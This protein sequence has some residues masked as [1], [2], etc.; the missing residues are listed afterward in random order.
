MRYINPRLTLTLTLT[1]SGGLVGG[2]CYDCFSTSY[3]SPLTFA[4][5]FYAINVY[6]SAGT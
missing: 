6:D 5:H 1:T 2:Q 4:F 3:M